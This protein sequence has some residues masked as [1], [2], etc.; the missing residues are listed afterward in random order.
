MNHSP[1]PWVVC[2]DATQ[3]NIVLIEQ[4]AERL[5]EEHGEPSVIGEVDLTGDGI[6]KQTGIANARLIAA[7]PDMLVCLEDFVAAYLPTNG[8]DLSLPMLNE[9]LKAAKGLIAQVK[10]GH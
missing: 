1:G 8:G 6:D 10:A 3:P 4:D 7:A 9:V 2:T 5:A